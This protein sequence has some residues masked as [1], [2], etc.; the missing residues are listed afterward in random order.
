MLALDAA[1]AVLVVFIAAEFELIDDG[2]SLAEFGACVDV[3]M[4]IPL[5]PLLLPSTA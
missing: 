4:P 2:D 3:G 5:L 1:V